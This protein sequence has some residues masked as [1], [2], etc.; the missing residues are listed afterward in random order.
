MKP[1]DIDWN[2]IA[3]PLAISLGIALLTMGIWFASHLYVSDAE[4]AFQKANR[5]T[6]GLQRKIRQLQADIRVYNE[7]SEKYTQLKTRSIINKEQRLDWVSRFREVTQ[8]LK[9]RTARYEIEAHKPV[10][11][12]DINLGLVRLFASRM[13]INLEVLHEGDFL[14]LM[15]AFNNSPGLF[16]ASNCKLSLKEKKIVLN[17]TATNIS[18]YCDLDWYTIHTSTYN[19]LASEK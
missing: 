14:T 9:V 11:R 18:I 17:P 4:S 19:K 3:K 10:K 12:S 13:K 5:Q 7:N 2:Y 1:G 15:D 16:H 8:K 6:K